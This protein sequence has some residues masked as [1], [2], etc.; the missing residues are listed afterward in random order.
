MSKYASGESKVKSKKPF[1]GRNR[2]PLKGVAEEGQVNQT[3]YMNDN[4]GP[5]NYCPG[6]ARDC[7][8]TARA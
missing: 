2:S 6:T 8:G 1:I 3:V 7:P 4:M 5:T